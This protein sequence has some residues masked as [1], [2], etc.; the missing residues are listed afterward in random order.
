MVTQNGRWICISAK[1]GWKLQNDNWK[2][3]QLV[4][5]PIYGKPQQVVGYAKDGIVV[6][7]CQLK[8]KNLDKF[9][10]VKSRRLVFLLA[11]EKYFPNQA[12]KLLLQVYLTYTQIEYLTLGPSFKES[13]SYIFKLKKYT[14]YAV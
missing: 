10:K 14:A 2:K 11:I 9:M 6:I 13:F 7:D 3:I 12:V 1:D 5:I 8:S 4:L